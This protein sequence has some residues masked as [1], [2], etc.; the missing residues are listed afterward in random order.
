[1]CILHRVLYGF[2]C[3][4]TVQYVRHYIKC[5]EDRYPPSLKEAVHPIFN[6][7]FIIV[8]CRD[9]K[10][11]TYSIECFISLW[12]LSNL[13]PKLEFEV[14]LR[15]KVQ[16]GG[17]ANELWSKLLVAQK[18]S[19]QSCCLQKRRLGILYRQHFWPEFFCAVWPTP[20]FEQITVTVL[21]LSWAT[22]LHGH[23]G[24]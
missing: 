10:V 20:A 1:M 21:R 24:P 9:Q 11:R 2:Q 18:N 22:S 4:M 7:I 13:H 3:A 15:T 23:L 19:G 14:F 8:F 6:I 5:E 12:L 17:G 16:A